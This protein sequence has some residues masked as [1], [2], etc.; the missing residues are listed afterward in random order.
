[1]RLEIPLEPHRATNDAITL[2]RGTRGPEMAEI[3]ERWV[4]ARGRRIYCRVYRPRTDRALPA[5]VYF[6]GG[7]WVWGSVDTHDC[8][9]RSL[10]AGGEVSVGQRRLRAV[11]R[12]EN[13]RRRWRNAPRSCAMSHA[14]AP[15]GDWTRRAFCSAAIQP[16]ATWRWRPRCCCA[17]AAGPSLPVSSPPIRCATAVWTRRA[18]RNSPAGHVLTR[19][20]MAFYWSCYVPHEAD[21]AHPLAAP[22]R[23]DL[24]GLP[25][26]LVLLAELDVLRSEGEALAA[27]LREAAVPVECETYSGVLHGFFRATDG[28][29]K[30]RDA[31]AKAGAWIRRIATLAPH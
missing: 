6:H 28:V 12:S 24:T 8:A 13:S 20:K 21:R 26:V 1:M 3:T 18:T 25:P 7:G 2:A 17:T 11:A 27:K 15:T 4:A 19:D 22:L 14:K 5:L 31:V 29:Q 23:A 9:A 30:A 16:A 10:A